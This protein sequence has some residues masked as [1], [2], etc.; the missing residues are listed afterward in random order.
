M[1]YLTLNRR[2][3]D[4]VRYLEW[5]VEHAEEHGSTVEDLE[6]VL[7]NSIRKS[8]SRSTGIPYVFGYA[9]DDVYIIMV[10]E[11][12][13]EETVYPVTAFEVEED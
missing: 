6:Y 5:N 7:A 11:I 13:D 3:S 9:P 1:L 2:S 4:A 10:Y 12:I 8:T